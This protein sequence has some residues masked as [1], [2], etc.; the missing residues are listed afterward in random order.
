MQSC[1]PCP[2][3]AVPAQTAYFL[4][5]PVMSS[6]ERVDNFNNGDLSSG[7]QFEIAGL[8]GTDFATLNEAND[9]ANIIRNGTDGY[10]AITAWMAG[11]NNRTTGIV[12]F[13]ISKSSKEAVGHFRLLPSEYVAFAWGADGSISACYRESADQLGTDAQWHTV[14]S[15]SDDL[16]VDVVIAY[17]G[18]DSSYS[19]WFDGVPVVVNKYSRAVYN[20]QHSVPSFINQV[21]FFSESGNNG[22]TISL[23]N[24]RFGY[25]AGYGA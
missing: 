25:G 14:K 21:R 19:M 16:S 20:G 17:N 3:P 23:S 12:S 7:G 6:V 15:A 1:H 18:A 24:Y 8:E 9:K 4:E 2:A 22:D 11:G 10:A 5:V 13:T